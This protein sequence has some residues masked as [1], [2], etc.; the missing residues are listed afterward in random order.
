[1]RIDNTIYEKSYSFALRIIKLSQFLDDKHAYALSSQIIK[2]GTSIGANVAESQ[3]AQSKKDFVS[4]LSI[5]LKEAAETDYWINLLKDSGYINS[6]EY[7]SLI[8][9]CQE[10]EKLLTAI[11]KSSKE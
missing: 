5:S 2:S 8:K 11:I 4:K 7:L 9:D 10:L 1:M 3:Q 6:A